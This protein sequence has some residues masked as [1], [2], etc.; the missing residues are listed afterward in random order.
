MAQ[1]TIKRTQDLHEAFHAFSELSERLSESY[2]LLEDRVAVLTAELAAAR[3]ER[4]LQL[5]E[6]ERLANRLQ[7]LLEA[8]PGAVVVLDGEDIIQDYNPGAI[9]L[10]GEP[11][12]GESWRK[13][14]ARA[15]CG[16]IGDSC[17]VSFNNGRQ[18]SISSRALGSE[19]GRILL[20]KDDTEI[21]RLQEMLNRHQRLS[22]MGEMVARL[23]HQIRTPLASSMLYVS[24]LRK[25]QCDTSERTRYAEKTLVGL[26]QLER[27]VNDMLAFARGEEFTPETIPVS[28]LLEDL[29]QALEPQLQQCNGRLRLI[30]TCHDATVQG[31]RD[32]LLGAISN[33]AA[34]A[35]QA[36]PDGL[37]LV[38]QVSL[39]GAN[40]VRVVVSDNGPGIEPDIQDRIFEPFFTTRGGGTGLGLAVVRAVVQGHRG[41]IE[42]QSHPGQGTS[43]IIRLPNLLNEYALDSGLWEEGNNRKQGLLQAKREIAEAQR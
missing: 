39:D 34:N 21:R 27:M 26:R 16:T 4:L 35:M 7:Q 24:H 17:Y 10:L 23:A 25:A 6:K 9:E 30:N 20:L 2:R 28:A 1:N 33:L 8:L 22:S 36:R 41:D 13:V 19:P 31:N 5:A 15:A 43:F 32:M 11:L 3:S 38:I 40:T 29:R 14:L 18:V 12:H 42:V 37:E